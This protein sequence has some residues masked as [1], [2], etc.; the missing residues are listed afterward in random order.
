MLTYNP[1]YSDVKRWYVIYC[2][3]CLI[4]LQVASLLKVNPEYGGEGGSKGMS[5]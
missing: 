3:K 2:L 4:V 1:G 5:F